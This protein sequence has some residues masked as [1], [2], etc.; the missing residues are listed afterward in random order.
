MTCFFAAYIIT[1]P[2]IVY[3]FL[4]K[5]K[6]NLQDA[7]YKEKFESLYLNIDMDHENSTFLTTL[8]ALRRLFFSVMV[9]FIPNTCI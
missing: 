4:Y 9:M 3:T 7:T 2:G 1:F 5:C 8:F 6:E